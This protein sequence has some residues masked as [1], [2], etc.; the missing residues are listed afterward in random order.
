MSHP[1]GRRCR[2]QHRPELDKVANALT[3]AQII[4]AITDGGAAITTKAAA[5]KYTTQM[6]AYKGALSRAQI[7]DIAA[8][9]FTSTHP[10]DGPAIAGPD[11]TGP[12]SASRLLPLHV[13]RAPRLSV[14]DDLPPVS[15]SLRTPASRSSPSSTPSPSSSPSSA[16]CSPWALLPP[17]TPLA[18]ARGRGG[19]GHG[20]RIDACRRPRPRGAARLAH[21]RS[22]NRSA[23]LRD[24]GSRRSTDW[25]RSGGGARGVSRR[26]EP[27]RENDARMDSPAEPG[28]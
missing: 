1:H 13:R 7:Q 11:R 21:R 20:G 24:A 10:W 18:A 6:V 3:E 25:R 27:S 23:P 12:P 28:A 15:S 4:T 26:G 16:A 14:R 5:A 9:I 19:G 2:R 8:F 22:R 17:G